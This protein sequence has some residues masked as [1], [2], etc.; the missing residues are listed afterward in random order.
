[1]P[2]KIN[3]IAIV[4]E[5]YALSGK[6]YESVFGMK[7]SSRARPGR[8]VTV[9]D[10][11]VGLNINPRKP[12]R[13]ARLDHFGI[14]IDDF[15]AAFEQLRGKYPRVEWVKRP[16]TR[17]FAAIT[18]HDPDG[19]VFDL[20][21]KAA[22]NRADVYAEERQ[23]QERHIDHLAMRTLNPEI[24]AEFYRDLFGLTAQE[25][26]AGDPN[27][28]VSD[29]HVTLVIMPWHITDYEGTGIVSP[30]LDHIG[31]TVESLTQFKA[32]VDRVAGDNPL[33]SPAPVAAGP[34]GKA[35]L[36]LARRSCPL[37]EHQMADVDGI[38]VSATE[39]R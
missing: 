29:G 2:A 6:F 9:G 1:M 36:E 22:A 14:Q 32:D 21:Q 15:E 28:Y 20:S 26:K 13:P 5:N 38:F 23:L 17:P 31:F 18:T 8:A 12:G 4:S 33:L 16:S 11:Y 30:S 35:R 39:S 27:H 10:G 37:C 3:H 24:V 25:K 7:T 19:N 34:E